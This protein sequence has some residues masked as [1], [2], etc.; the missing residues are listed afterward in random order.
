MTANPVCDGRSI[1]GPDAYYHLSE[2]YLSNYLI[3][4]NYGFKH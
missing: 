1:T 2:F 3:R 4:N